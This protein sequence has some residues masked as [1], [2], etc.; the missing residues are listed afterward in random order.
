[1]TVKYVICL[2]V[3]GVSV[4]FLFVHGHCDNVPKIH[5][6]A[7]N[8]RNNKGILCPSVPVRHAETYQHAVA[9]AI[10]W[11]V[12]KNIFKEKDLHTLKIER[13]AFI[14][15]EKKNKPFRATALNKY[16]SLVA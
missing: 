3:S 9:C 2:K 14:K 11:C 6:R 12:N 7:L 5:V 15:K 4:S 13:H 1:M 8:A 10:N 16:G